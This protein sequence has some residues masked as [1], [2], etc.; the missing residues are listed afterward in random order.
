MAEYF[1][2]HTQ[3]RYGESAQ[4]IIEHALKC[5]DKNLRDEVKRKVVPLGQDNVSLANVD[6]IDPSYFTDEAAI[7]GK[8]DEHE[9]LLREGEIYSTGGGKIEGFDM[10]NIYFRLIKVVDEYK[11][12]K[13]NSII[14]KEVAFDKDGNVID[15]NPTSTR[16]RFS[17]SRMMCRNFGIEYDNGYEIW[18]NTG[19]YELVDKKEGNAI[20]VDPTDLSTYP[21]SKIDKSVRKILLSLRGYKPKGAANVITPSGAEMPVRE[22]IENMCVTAK[23]DIAG[24]YG[25]ASF[26]KGH[27]FKFKVLRGKSLFTNNGIGN[28]II[29]LSV[30]TTIANVPQAAN[31]P[32]KKLGIHPESLRNMTANDIFIVHG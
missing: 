22:L 7:G 4:N 32:D 17:L 21:C 25:Y 15:E 29:I 27:L 19:N 18:L 28:P 20:H 26:K 13:L 6:C 24:A 10:K 3:V 11:G 9:G 23:D 30:D 14:I 16:R 5:L 31:V 2:S 1:S 8:A 12:N